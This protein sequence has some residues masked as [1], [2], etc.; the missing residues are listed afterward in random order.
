M[1]ERASRD[2][3]RFKNEL[4]AVVFMC[5]QFWM[6]AF[7]KNIDNLKT[8]HQVSH[9]FTPSIYLCLCVCLQDTYVLHDNAFR[10]LLHISE[11]TQY[12]DEAHTVSV[13][14][15]THTFRTHTHTHSQYLVFAC[16]LL[17]GALSNV[18]IKC[19]VTAGVTSMPACKKTLTCII[20][21]YIRTLLPPFS[22]LCRYIPNQSS[23]ITTHTL[24][25]HLLIFK[26]FSIS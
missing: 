6:M 5:K 18:G 15:N 16:G 2:H 21:T 26:T 17:A 4:D 22:V 1:V 23:L 24:L 19:H 9:S 12:R 7:N 13:L 3:P 20:H 14:L 11:G 8:N 25:A 10:L